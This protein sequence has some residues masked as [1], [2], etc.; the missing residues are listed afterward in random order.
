MPSGARVR[1][2]ESGLL[3]RLLGLLGLLG[4]VCGRLVLGLGSH[5]FEVV[6]TLSNGAE[7]RAAVGWQVLRSN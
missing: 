5:T 2:C 1:S 3:G 4:G 7:V 6:L